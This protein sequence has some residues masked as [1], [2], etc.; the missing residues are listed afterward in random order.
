VQFSSVR[1]DVASAIWRARWALLALAVILSAATIFQLRAANRQALAEKLVSTSPFNVAND[2]S[3]VEFASEEAKPLYRA[4]CAS[5][6][7]EKMQGDPAIGA[8]NL[9][10][11]SWMYGDG[12]VFEIERTIQ[13]GIR[14][15]RSR[16]RDVT[17]MPA[18]GQRGLLAPDQIQDLVQYILAMNHRPHNPGAVSIG[19]SIYAGG[20]AACFDCHGSAARGSPVYG[21]PDLTANAWAWG[22]SPDQIYRSIFYGRHGTMP[23]WL[24]SLSVEKIRALAVYIHVQ[25]HP[26]N[27]DIK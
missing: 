19:A 14:D 18:Y 27:G 10:D 6:H 2:P 17:E 24:N 1:F 11:I 25:S 8:P 26:P 12:S 7:G 20:A 22:G 9:T 4:H 21:S 16:T 3:L 23:G 13:F 15:A 5:C